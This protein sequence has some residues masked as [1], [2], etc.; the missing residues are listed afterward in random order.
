M[1][2][3]DT[4]I[5]TTAIA[6]VREHGDQAPIFAA[7]E[8]DRLSEE[9]DLDGAAY[10]RLVLA[11]VRRM[12]GIDAQSAPGDLSGSF[13]LESMPISPLPR[14]RGWVPLNEPHTFVK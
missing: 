10:W 8:A 13:R 1:P 7:M 14:Q 9:G 12:V 3:P 4:D 2:P 6:M 11:A 5:P